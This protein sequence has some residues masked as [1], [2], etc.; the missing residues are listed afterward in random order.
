PD[1]DELIARVLAADPNGIAVMFASN[2][3]VLTQAF[4]DRLGAALKRHGVDLH[5]RV[6]FLGTGIAHP[7][8]L[9]LNQ[10][11]DVMLDTLHWSGGNTSLD[12]LAMGLPVVTF[13]GTLMR[14]RQ[15]FGM[16]RTM[17]VA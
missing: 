15:S 5:E 10:L 4:A 13:P 7:T 3:D 1:N 11:C 16:L 14:G 12:A 8:Y 9:R 6:L 2:H 17:G